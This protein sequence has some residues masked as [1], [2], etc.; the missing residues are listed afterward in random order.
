M[1]VI[2]ITMHPHKAGGKDYAALLQFAHR[3]AFESRLKV[4]L[5]GE[6]YGMFGGMTALQEAHPENGLTGEIWK[7]TDINVDDA[8]L[9]L[10]TIKEAT[11][12]DLK[13]LSI[14]DHLKPHFTPFRYAFF[15]MHHRFV[16][17]LNQGTR[18]LSHRAALKLLDST[19]RHRSVL[20]E[21]RNTEITLTIEQ[22][23][24]ILSQIYDL[25]E[26]HHMRIVVNRPN[27]DDADPELIKQI[28]KELE[29]QHA[30]QQIT[31]LE[32][33]AGESLK[34]NERNKKLAKVAVQTGQ[35]IAKGKNLDGKRVSI[36]TSEHPI[37]EQFDYDE[38]AKRSFVQQFWNAA[39]Q[40][41]SRLRGHGQD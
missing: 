32:R 23:P 39:E 35:V 20:T 10:K 34:P 6:S 19:I 2:N 30:R 15:P 37:A 3:Q 36:D 22:K 27:P 13:G 5:H 40:I 28:E 18:W 14:P 24:D 25:Q 16:F 21:Y 38:K 9:N 29:A 7:F 31:E 17:Q 1:G 41:L 11:T 26:L 33:S 8:W 12:A 4:K